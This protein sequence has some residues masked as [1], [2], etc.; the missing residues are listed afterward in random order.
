MP[1]KAKALFQF[2]SLAFM[3]QGILLLNQI[4]LLPIQL[5]VWGTKTAAEWYSILAVAGVA[6]IADF[7]L[8]SAGHLHLTRWAN[9]PDDHDA[10]TEF[11]L[12]LGL[13]SHPGCVDHVDA[14]GG[15]LRLPT[16]LPGPGLSAVANGTAARRRVGDPPVHSRYLSRHPGFYT[17]AEAGYF[18]LVAGRLVL[19]VGALLFFHAQPWV[20]AWIWFLTCVV[21]LVQQSSTLPAGG[22]VEAL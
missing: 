22:T 5:R 2:A 21:A 16:F 9:N 19:S 4:V 1:G 14:A 18:V 11:H 7:G 20:L 17:E 15:G 3:T 6:S 8:R 13:A 10:E 12:A